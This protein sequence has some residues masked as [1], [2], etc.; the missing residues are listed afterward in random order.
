MR[1]AVRALRDYA[2]ALGVDFV[3]PTSRVRS[4][5]VQPL[6]ET[7]VL[8]FCRKARTLTESVHVEQVAG[9]SNISS[10]QGGAYIK[11]NAASGSATVDE[12]R[13]PYR[14]VLIQFGW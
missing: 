12:Y 10:I 2:T 9:I 7:A 3:M 1:L 14:G 8:C 4:F 11:Y 5:S 6:F 13:G